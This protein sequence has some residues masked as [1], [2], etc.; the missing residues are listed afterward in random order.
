M[1]AADAI[2]ALSTPPG[3]SARAIVRLSGPGVFAL[4]NNWTLHGAHPLPLQPSRGVRA[5]A[6]KLSGLELPLLIAAFPGPVSFTG[7]D[8]AELLLPGNPHLIQR[9]IDELIALARAHS[10]PI[11]P[12][13]PGEFSARAYLHDRMTLE[14]AEGVAALIAA[15]TTHEMDDARQLLS[16]AR[17]GQ[18]RSLA[19]ECA[20]LL[21]LVEAGIDFTDQEDVVAIE[22]A[23]LQR[24]VRAMIATLESIVGADAGEEA[25]RSLPRVVLAGQPNAG[26]ST[27][28]NALLG[29]PRAVVSPQPGTTRDVIEEELEL[30]GSKIVLCDCAGIEEL[31]AHADASGIARDMQ[32]R[33]QEAIAQADVVLWCDPLAR[34]APAELPPT[35]ARV[36]R[37]QTKADLAHTRSDHSIEVSALDGYNLASLRRAIADQAWTGPARQSRSVPPRHRRAL[38]AAAAALRGAADLTTPPRLVNP[39]LI[40]TRL[41]AALDAIGELTGRLTPDD[42]L[43]RVFATFCVGK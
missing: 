15:E 22:P 21:A 31:R 33:T 27:L 25:E 30:S 28:F 38:A 35:R 8:V 11:R 36:L 23:A 34:F 1:T 16:G 13:N 41:R 18:Y 42:V 14:Q 24:R 43:G 20:T 19:E 7:E 2:L 17:G 32:L 39:E 3:F 26:K 6:G 29:R 9:V 4:L 12:A 37:V 40:A 5:T 10:I